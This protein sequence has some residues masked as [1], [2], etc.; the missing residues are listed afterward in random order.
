MSG[1]FEVIAGRSVGAAGT[2]PAADD[3]YGIRTLDLYVSVPPR[4]SVTFSSKEYG[5]DQGGPGSTPYSRSQRNWRPLLSQ[6]V[7]FRDGG[8]TP[9]LN[10]TDPGSGSGSVHAPSTTTRTFSSR[11]TFS[12][13]MDEST[14]L[15]ATFESLT[16]IG[17]YA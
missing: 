7:T 6:G 16:S 13:V 9:E 11:Y 8:P 12:T 4:P 15:G 17:G 2:R 1:C 3:G 10:V 5:R 14:K